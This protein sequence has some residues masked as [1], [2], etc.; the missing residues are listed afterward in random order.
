VSLPLDHLVWAVPDLG[1]AVEAFVARTGVEPVP[2][3]RHPGLGTE[4]YLVAL[5]D[6]SGGYLE[7]IG[8]SGEEPTAVQAR[9]FGIDDLVAP[10]LVTWAVRTGDLPAFTAAAKRAGF[11]VGTPRSMSRTTSTGET[12]EWHLTVPPQPVEF[13]LV[14][15]A[16]DWGSTPRPA[17]RGLPIVELRAFRAT[18]PRPD[19]LRAGLRMLGA[20]L[21]V[22]RGQPALIAEI[23]GPGGRIL[24]A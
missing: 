16:I 5:S 17:S 21:D 13:G 22:E 12:L 15:F 7:I 10:R 6:R 19:Q 18:H 1:D 23:Q 2:G 11:D 14:P 4:N 24:L 20:D 9:P 8:P 3:G